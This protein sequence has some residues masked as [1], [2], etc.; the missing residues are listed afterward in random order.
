MWNSGV[1]F[2]WSHISRLRYEDLECGLKIV[3]KFTSDHIN[4]TLYSVMRVNLA[5]EVL[6]EAVGNV[7]NSFFLEETAGTAIFYIMVDKFF[8]CLNVRNTIEHIK[9]RK[10]IP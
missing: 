4:L 2:L 7:L 3:N 9:N 1:F 5:T 8:D 10:I 6:S